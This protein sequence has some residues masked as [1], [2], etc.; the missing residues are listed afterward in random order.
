MAKDSI[1]ERLSRTDT[2]ASRKLKEKKL[3]VKDNGRPLYNIEINDEVPDM[4]ALNSTRSNES[5]S[6]KRSTFSSSTASSRRSVKSYGSRSVSSRGSS[7]SSVF[8]RLHK[9]GTLSSV[10]K[11]KKSDFYDDTKDKKFQ[12][13]DYLRDLKGNTRIFG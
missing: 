2:Y 4:P 12:A 13:E 5:E 1:F 11:D 7:G 9:Q 6:T 8:D 3:T 10:R